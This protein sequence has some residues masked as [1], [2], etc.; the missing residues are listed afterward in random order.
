MGISTVQL[1]GSSLWFFVFFLLKYSSMNEKNWGLFSI[2][3]LTAPPGYWGKSSL[4][5]NLGW[6]WGCDL[7][8]KDVVVGRTVCVFCRLEFK[9]DGVAEVTLLL[10]GKLGGASLE[11][12]VDLLESGLVG[13]GKKSCLY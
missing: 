2:K 8:L 12:V 3:T 5:G 1:T 6:I 11:L 10:L 7:P 9:D 13:G 4:G